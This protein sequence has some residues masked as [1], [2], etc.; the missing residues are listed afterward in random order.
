M[1]RLRGSILFCFLLLVLSIPHTL[2]GATYAD[3]VLDII[4]EGSFYAYPDHP[5]GETFASFF[6]GASWAYSRRGDEDLVRFS[7]TASFEGVS[8][9]IE[10]I[11]SVN[12]AEGT[13]N[14]MAWRVAGRE[15]DLDD[16]WPFLDEIFSYDSG[17]WAISIVRDGYFYDWPYPTV[18]EA[19]DLFFY[20]TYWDYFYTEE[21]DIF[22]YF[23]GD[24]WYDDAPLEVYLEFYVDLNEET[25]ET[26]YMEIDEWYVDYNAY[27][28]MLDRIYNHPVNVVKDG[29]FGVLPDMPIGNA[30]D[31]Y[32]DDP[33][34]EF[35]IST[36]DL[37]IVEFVGYVT[38]GD[39]LFEVVI[40]FYVEPLDE[41]F[42]LFYWEIDGLS[43]G[44]EPFYLL[45]DGIQSK[46]AL[47]QQSSN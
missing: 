31:T 25:F 34:W 40:Q 42:E 13:F 19:F 21:G 5:V 44:Y 11:F 3:E 2:S 4:R 45:L 15:R 20:D 17:S 37:D 47:L 24:A 41:Y 9:R 18:G 39:L 38:V 1:K 6:D 35:F 30:F 23:I 7:G 28:E 16:L 10:I 8:A 36:D 46:L 43:Q 27:L 33:Y 12:K 29:S 22:V 32:F 14:V 26:Y